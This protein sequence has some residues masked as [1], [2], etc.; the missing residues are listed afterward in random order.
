MMICNKVR[1]FDLKHQICFDQDTVKFTKLNQSVDFNVS[2]I[3]YSTVPA[4]FH[5]LL[6]LFMY[7]ILKFAIILSFMKICIEPEVPRGFERSEKTNK[8]K[9]WT[10][11]PL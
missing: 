4:E 11:W 8:N 3:K 9:T 5:N 10:E 7:T 6:I 2:K 1:Q